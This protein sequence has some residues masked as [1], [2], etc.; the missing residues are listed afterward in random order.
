MLLPTS[1]TRSGPL[2]QPGR[3]RAIAFQDWASGASINARS[4]GLPLCEAGLVSCGG[5]APL[6]VSQGSA[7]P[8]PGTVVHHPAG[9]A[10]GL[11]SP[12]P[13]PRTEHRP[14]QVSILSWSSC[15]ALWQAEAG[16]V[17][18]H[19]ADGDTEALGF[20]VLR[21]SSQ[22]AQA[23]PANAYT[24]VLSMY[25]RCGSTGRGGGW[26]EGDPGLESWQEGGWGGYGAALLRLLTTSFPSP[27]RASTATSARLLTT[28]RH[29]P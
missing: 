23:S 19:S 7:P 9:T 24:L 8:P 21:S 15:H 28:T 26:C 5:W 11:L 29:I 13:L 18:P 17:S 27:G 22:G 4:P 25:S 6:A 16:A 3:G 2:P 10:S 1:F 14:Q 20:P 12:L